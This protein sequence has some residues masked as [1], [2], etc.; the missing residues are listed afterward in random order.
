MN[1]LTSP[2]LT[3]KAAAAYLN[4]TTVTLDR[5][6]IPK[7]RIRRKVLITKDNIDAW[8]A[9]HTYTDDSRSA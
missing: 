7:T 2:L 4:I 6:D 9:G 5:L 8:I 3:R 1:T